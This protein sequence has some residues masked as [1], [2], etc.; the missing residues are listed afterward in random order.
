MSSSD[1]ME[2]L[3]TLQKK[4]LITLDH[5]LTMVAELDGDMQDS[6]LVMEDDEGDAGEIAGGAPRLVQPPQLLARE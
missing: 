1:K 5:Y 6:D 2:Q 3:A 4:G